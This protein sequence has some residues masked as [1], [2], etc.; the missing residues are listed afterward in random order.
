MIETHSDPIKDSLVAVLL[1]AHS[2]ELLF[3]SALISRLLRLGFRVHVICLSGSLMRENECRHSLRIIAASA[4]PLLSIEFPGFC[5]T[6]LT[7]CIPQAADLVR[8]RVRE[9]GCTL[10]LTVSGEDRNGD[11]FAAAS[12]SEIGL[13]YDPACSL[14]TFCTPSTDTSAWR[15]NLL[16]ELTE[17][18]VSTKLASAAA[19]TSEN[20][21]PFLQPEY[22]RVMHESWAFTCNHLSTRAGNWFEPYRIEKLVMGRAS[23]TLFSCLEAG[24]A[25]PECR[26]TPA[27]GAL[28]QC[29]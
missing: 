2:D 7:E 19:H 12:L 18:D 15:P 3:M 8:S 27:T 22:L 10:L 14:M 6:R 4:E 11:H 20:H 26:P 9:L 29:I 21:K 23:A 5:D 24:L 16:I 13:R 17:K 1:I 25:K 28:H